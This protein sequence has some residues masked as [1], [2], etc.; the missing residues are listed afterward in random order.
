MILKSILTDDLDG[1]TRCIFHW[2]ANFEMQRNAIKFRILL[3]TNGKVI[4]KV[5]LADIENR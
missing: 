2:F 1:S 5:E 4:T 3:K